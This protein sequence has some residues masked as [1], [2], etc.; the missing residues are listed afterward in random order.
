MG[1]SSEVGEG[2]ETGEDRQLQIFHHERAV[3]S[4]TKAALPNDGGPAVE[5]IGAS[6]TT[7]NPSDRSRCGSSSASP[8]GSSAVCDGKWYTGTALQHPGRRCTLLLAVFQPWGSGVDKKH[9][10]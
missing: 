2:R 6:S 3:T 4:G 5:P 8:R 7:T 10:C 9:I 1:E